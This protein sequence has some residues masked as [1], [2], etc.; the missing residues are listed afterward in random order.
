[1]Y[2]TSIVLD[3]NC[4]CAIFGVAEHLIEVVL[5]VSSEIDLCSCFNH[6]CTEYV[7]VQSK[8]IYA[9]GQ[10]DIPNVLTQVHMLHSRGK[11]N[12]TSQSQSLR[13]G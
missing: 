7:P 4:T 11:Y 2:L 9:K 13:H 8:Q 12:E 3:I 6:E 10:R 1:M 5:C